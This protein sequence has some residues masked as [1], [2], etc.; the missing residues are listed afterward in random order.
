M[1]IWQAIILGAVQGF[2]EFLPV[3]SS[4][5][6][7]VMERW[8]GVNTDG[9]LFFDIALHVGTLVPVFIVFFKSIKGLFK[10]PYDK[11]LYL[12]VAS[13][14]AAAVGFVLQDK[15]EY[16]YKGGGI[17][18]AV[19]LSVSFV[20][21]A[22]ELLLTEKISEK[23]KNALPLS[24]KSSIIMGVCQGFAVIPGL[25]R[26]G[27]VITGGTISKL[28]R[29]S[30]AEFAFL[31]SIPIIL[32]ATLLSGVKVIKNGCDIEILPVIFGVI[33]AA[34]TGYIAVNAMLKAVKRAK[35][36]GFAVYLIIL[37]AASVLTKVIFGV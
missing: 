28:G 12:F 31:M 9:G 2:T 24:L 22:L 5:H 15:I 34:V 30:N 13:L 4:G 36:K 21:T 19:L 23:N 27:T 20:L 7:L 14:P 10:K 11:L 35:Y 3:S 8:L 6:L 25:S 1:R 18:S 29:N 16:L 26:S 37:A 33:S 32:G 17:L